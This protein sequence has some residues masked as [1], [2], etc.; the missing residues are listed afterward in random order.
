MASWGV[1]VHSDSFQCFG[2]K[3][4]PHASWAR[5]FVVLGPE[6]PVCLMRT[7]SLMF[8]LSTAIVILATD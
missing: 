8:F 7:G 2:R 6:V 1:Q 3:S 4:K 5:R